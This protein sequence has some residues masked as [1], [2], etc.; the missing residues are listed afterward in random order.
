MSPGPP[1]AMQPLRELYEEFF[2][3]SVRTPPSRQILSPWMWAC[4]RGRALHPPSGRQDSPNHRGREC[5]NPVTSTQHQNRPSVTSQTIYN[6]GQRTPKKE[7]FLFLKNWFF[8]PKFHSI[9]FEELCSKCRAGS[10]AKTSLT[11]KNLFYLKM[12]L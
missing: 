11:M 5:N 8:P 3:F 7:H 6:H 4:G 9:F 2:S 10:L 1:C 12:P